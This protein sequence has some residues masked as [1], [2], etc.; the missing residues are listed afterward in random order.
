ME[1]VRLPAAQQHTG[2]ADD[3]RYR[4]RAHLRAAVERLG[5]QIAQ[6]AVQPRTELLEQIQA[7]ILLAHL[8]AMEGG[9][10]N[11]QLPREV[12]VCRIP[13]SPS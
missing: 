1:N 8:D 7:D 12:P 2:P 11:P 10:R 4:P 6:G 3:L 5:E 13:A 9:F